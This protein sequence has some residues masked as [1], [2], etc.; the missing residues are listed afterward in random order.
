MTATI[1]PAPAVSRLEQALR[2]RR[3]VITTEITPP[4]SFDPEDL[5]RKAEPLRGLADAVNVTDGASARAHLGAADRRRAAGPRRHR[6]DPAVDLPRPQPHRPSRRPDGRGRD[7]RAQSPDAD[8]RRSQGRRPARHQA[9][10]RHRFDHAVRHGAADERT[11][12]TADRP[13]D[14]RACPILHRRR[15][16]RRSIRRRTGSRS[17]SPPRSRRAQN[18]PRPSS[19]WMPASCGATPNASPP[20]RARATLR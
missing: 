5:L 7:R 18:S 11:G 10:V 3:F 1:A 14:R 12:R 16:M 8:G 9:G 2:A 13:Q 17:S 4:V 19:A 6:A 15:P 20:T